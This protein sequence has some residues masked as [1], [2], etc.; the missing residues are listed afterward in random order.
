VDGTNRH[1]R[2]SIYETDG[3]NQLE[4]AGRSDNCHEQKF[5]PPIPECDDSPGISGY[6]VS[7]SGKSHTA[8]CFDL[9]SR[10]PPTYAQTH[11]EIQFRCTESDYVAAQ[12]AWILHRPLKIVRGYWYS[13]LIICMVI[14]GLIMNPQKWR[15]DLFLGVMAVA[16]AVPSLLLM[17]WKWHRQFNQS[18]LADADITATVD[19]RGVTFSAGGNRKTH[20]WVGFSQIYESSQT[21][22]LEK[23]ESDFLFLPRRAMSPVQR[24]ELKRLAAVSAQNCKVTLATPLA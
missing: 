15:L 20:M 14:V 9:K 19:E 7:K 12:N 3:L 8:F 22:V 6:P 10:V 16:V 11:M 13:L 1:C 23:G 4:Q 18:N 24:G 2:P 21:V 5:A 17:R